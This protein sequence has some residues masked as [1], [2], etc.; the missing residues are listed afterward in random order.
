MQR[1]I[2][3]ES[4]YNDLFKPIANSDGLGYPTIK[5]SIKERVLECAVDTRKFEIEHYWKYAAYFWA[6]IASTKD[7]N[8]NSFI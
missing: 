2:N 8:N 6:F 5:K 7:F 3:N 4:E 1:S